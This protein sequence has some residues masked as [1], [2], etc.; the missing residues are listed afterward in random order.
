MIRWS[1]DERASV[2]PDERA[3]RRA[4]SEP[5]G[6]CIAV[7][8]PIIP[9]NGIGAVGCVHAADRRAQ[10]TGSCAS[11][12][13]SP[14]PSNMSLRALIVDDEAD[15]RENLRLMLEEHCPEVQVVGQAGSAAEAR[16][17]IQEL[18]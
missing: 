6:Y 12:I 3:A 15:A 11:V 5:S 17:R 10:A 4:K 7:S 1:S 8:K 18:Q 16:T 13:F 2:L 9:P 14:N